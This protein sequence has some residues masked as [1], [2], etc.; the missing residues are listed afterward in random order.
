MALDATG[1]RVGDDLRGPALNP[2][3]VAPSRLLYLDWL[4][5]VAVLAM[6]HAHILDSWTQATDRTTRLYYSLQWIG[7]VASPL[8]LFLAGVAMAMSAGSKARHAGSI[9]VGAQAARRRGWEIFLLA[10]VFRLQQEILGFGPL[11]TLLKVDMLNIMGL[12]LVAASAIWQA[13]S[14]PRLRAAI[15]LAITAA[16]TFLTPLVRALS[17]L[18]PLPDPLEAY[19]RPAGN[20]AAFPLFPWAGYLFAGVAVGDLIDNLRAHHKTPTKLHVA[21]FGTGV[22]A[23]A[24]ATWASYQ[25]A[26]YATADFWHD[27]PTIFFIR[28]GVVATLVAISWL[29]ESLSERGI[30]PLRAF[31]ALVTLGRSS[32]F[33]Y[34]IHVEMVYGLLA[35]P[36]KRQMPGWGTQ[37]AWLLL[38]VALY[39]IVVWKNR[40]LEGYE[41]PRRARIFAAVLR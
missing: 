6:V 16:I 25:P 36:L 28:L 9:Q 22:G 5:G 34:W 2:R 3:A 27:S 24:L 21:L 10:F 41:L 1:H 17:W 20:Y 26:L 33:V 14:H 23:V 32:L 40:A 31:R 38:C 7:G 39:W 15:F 18:A 37:V 12:A 29:I 4:R 19:L 13:T 11:Q 30:L 35:E 8:F